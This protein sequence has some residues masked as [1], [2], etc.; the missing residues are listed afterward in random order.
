[1][2]I[3]L[4]TGDGRA[5]LTAAA[6]GPGSLVLGIDASPASMI[7]ASRRAA[8]T[9][10]K[11]G[12]PNALFIVSAVEALPVEVAGWADEVVILFPW[13]SLLRG[14]LGLD[15]TVA[16]ANARLVKVGGCVRIVLSV[17]ER[18]GIAEVPCLDVAS[19]GEIAPRQA[20][21]GLD[22]LASRPATADDLAA[23]RSSWARR[24]RSDSRRPVWVLE[25]RRRVAPAGCP[26]A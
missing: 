7:E 3:D 10:A 21:R 19:V 24:L 5:V 11:G 18:D 20:C 6:R 26:D 8:R 14:A 13:G 17:T 16:D 9:T 12:L 22:L 1:M 4:G 2:I 25:F 23:T 15:A